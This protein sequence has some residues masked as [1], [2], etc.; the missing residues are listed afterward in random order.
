[1]VNSKGQAKTTEDI[2]EELGDSDYNIIITET[3][4][5]NKTGVC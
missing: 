2:F 4:W 5:Y 3:Y 1:M